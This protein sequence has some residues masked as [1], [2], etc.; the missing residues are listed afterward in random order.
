M[1][2]FANRSIIEILKKVVV[3]SAI[4]MSLHTI[5]NWQEAEEAA[6]GLQGDEGLIVFMAKR[7][8]ISYFPEMGS[9][10]DF[11]NQ[12]VGE[13]NFLLIYPFRDQG[14]GQLEKR[15]VNNHDDFVE[16]GQI[17]GKVFAR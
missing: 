14:T 5:D 16:I 9:I 13:N 6:I 1:S 3:K 17:I 4:E 2:F 7:G 11:L 10:P 8:M 12:H 15:S